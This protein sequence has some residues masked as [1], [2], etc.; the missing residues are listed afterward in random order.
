[1]MG[2]EFRRDRPRYYRKH[3]NGGRVRSEYLGSGVLA[4]LAMALD[5]K[6][7]EDAAAERAEW[8]AWKA[9]LDAEES[10]IAHY[11]H[12]VDEA[13]SEVLTAAGY[14][15]PSRKLQWMKRHG[16]RRKAKTQV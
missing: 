8:Q 12:T 14:H 5:E 13:V 15:R 9:E 3:W 6:R 4:L 7:S 16:P 1:M 11:L 2:L 10:Q